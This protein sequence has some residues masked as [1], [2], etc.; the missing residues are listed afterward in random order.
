[1]SI[2]ENY[3]I[4]VE[5]DNLSFNYNNINLLEINSNSNFFKLPIKSPSYLFNNNSGFLFNPSYN[6]I[7]YS[8]SSNIFTNDLIVLG[9]LQASSFPSNVLILDEDNKINS[10]YLPSINNFIVYNTN[11]IAIGTSTP[12]ANIQL[13]DGNAYFKNS[14]IGIGTLP[15]YY[16]HLNK[17]DTM[18]LQ[19]AFVISSNSKHIIDIYTELETIVINNDGSPLDTNA[20]LN[21]M[22]LLKAN[23]I[24]TPYFTTSNKSTIINNELF[25]NNINSFQ[26]SIIIHSNID[27][28]LN[29]NS[30]GSLSSNIINLNTSVEFLNK[31]I[32]SNSNLILTTSN[33]IIDN[34][35]TSSITTSNLNVINIDSL[36]SNPSAESVMDFKGKIRLYNDTENVIIKIFSNDTQLFLIT[37]NNKLYS[38]SSNQVSLISSNFFYNTF[39]AKYNNYAYTFNNNLYLNGIKIL[40]NTII[41]DFALSPLNHIFY[42]NQIGEVISLNLSTNTQIVINNFINLRKIES[43]LDNSFIVLTNDNYIYHYVNNNYNI[44]TLSPNLII[45]D[46]AS[47]DDHTILQTNQ[48][49]WSFGGNTNNLTLKKGYS[50]IN[51]SSIGLKINYFNQTPKIV[52]I[53]VIK[54]SS[55][56]CDINSNVYI[57]GNINKLY[58]TQ[59]IYKIIDVNNV[60]DFCCDNNSV[61]LLSYF[62]DL[63]TLGDNNIPNTINLNEDF[64]GTSIKSKGSIVIG[65]EY[66]YKNNPR[67]SL[68]VQNFVGIGTN[69]SYN[70]AYSLIINGNINII[71][72][73]YN[74]GV[75]FVGG[76]GSGTSVW[77]KNVNDIYYNSGNVGVGLVK[78]LAPL[79]INGNAMFESNVIIKGK[80][81]AKDISPFIIKNSTNIYYR[82][83]VDINSL[84]INDG[85]FNINTIINSSN[86]IYN[87]L[88]QQSL[89]SSSTNTTYINPIIINENSSVIVSS[90]FTL[91]NINNNSNVLIYKCINNNWIKYP[92]RDIIS[93]NSSFGQS[94]AISKDGSNIFIGAYKDKL[95]SGIQT[96]GIYKYSFDN[97]NN[98]IRD[99]IRILSINQN[100]S[101][102]YIGNKIC[103]SSD[104]NILISTI[105][106]NNYKIYIQDIKENIEKIID[107]TPYNVFHTSFNPLNPNQ[108]FIDT[109]NDGSIIIMNYIFDTTINDITLFAYFNL[110]IIKDFDIY[111]LKFNSIHQNSFITSLSISSD[112]SRIFI[113]TTLGHH[114]IYEIDFLDYKTTN[115]NSTTIIKYFELQPSYY[116]YKFGYKGVLSKNGNFFHLSNSSIVYIYKYNSV[117]SIW[118][119]RKLLNLPLNIHN[120]S[121]S[122]DGNGF[123]I[124]IS[125]IK[126]INDTNLIDDIL[127]NNYLYNIHK[128]NLVFNYTSSNLNVNTDVFIN[129]NITCQNLIANGSNVYNVLTNNLVNN[130][131]QNGMMYTSNNLIYSSSNI[132]YNDNLKIFQFDTEG[133][134]TSNIYIL[135]NI[136]TASNI[137][138]TYGDIISGKGILSTSNIVSYSNII[139]TSNISTTYGNIRSAS[140]ISAI[141]NITAN[142]NII[143]GNRISCYFDIM[144]IYGN[145]K[146]G[147]NL[148]ADKDIIAINNISTTKGNIIGASNLFITSN[149][150][151]NNNIYGNLF[152]GDG[153]NLS[154]INPSNIISPIQINKGGTGRNY[155]NNNEIL[156]GNGSNYINSYN[157]FTFDFDT[158]TLNVSNINIGSNLILNGENFSNLNFSF[159]K[160][161]GINTF[162][163]GGLG[164]NR[165]SKSNLIFANESNKLKETPNLKWDEV[166]SNFRIDGNLIVKKI[167]GDGC[168][169]SNLRVDFETIG[170]IVPFHKG[171]LGFNKISKSNFIYAMEDNFVS[172]TSNIRWDTSNF[173]VDGN[174]HSQFFYGDGS[175]L[176]NIKVDFETIGGIIPFNKGGL[177]FNKISKSNLIFAN[178]DNQLIETSNIRWDDVNS[179]FIING[180]IYGDGLNISNINPLN[181]ISP[182]QI[183]KG[184]T[185]RNFFNNGEILFG[186]GYNYLNS[187][188]DFYL[189]I[190]TKTLNV[191]NINISSNIIFN[192]G[193]FSNLNFDFEQINGIIGFEKGGLGFNQI[194]KS[195]LIFA[196]EDNQ[197]KQTSNIRWDDVNSNFII[198]GYIFGDGS[199]I[200]N[201]NYSN[202]TGIINFEK[203]GLGFNQIS[204]SNLIFA[205]ENNQLKET[206]NIQWDE[207]NSNLLIKGY[208]FGDGSNISNLNYSNITGIINFE[209][210][211]LGFNQISKSNMI[212]ANENNKLKE[213]SNIRW[214]DVNSNLLIKGALNIGFNE[215]DE[216]YKIKVDGNIYLSG[217]VIGLSDINLKKNIEIIENPL[218]KINKLRGV[219][220]NYINNDERRQIGLIAQEVEKII[221][222]VV[223]ITNDDT[224]AIAYNNLIGLLIEGIKEL[225]NIIKSK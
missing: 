212:F 180:Y 193:N 136:S 61:Y 145:I 43:Y 66:F 183:D 40:D 82:G 137:S 78:P 203:G 27:L 25:I 151:V 39:K 44:I 83:K 101:Y 134:F 161:T 220:F 148:T 81:I 14:R 163:K 186:S 188:N 135:S 130:Y 85:T 173:F 32:R 6:S 86:L 54:N 149:I 47:G 21:V 70:P 171:G 150:F 210:G 144:T 22:G 156:I 175:N 5:N 205:N 94:L 102:N 125:I 91:D 77:K 38:Y 152:F 109:N 174:I 154:N 97:L 223:Y 28:I 172:E 158:N 84:E 200:S 57:F 74:N 34:L 114:Y 127:I 118:N 146:S 36:T 216:N 197:L 45:E 176:S 142:N 139:S 55:I 110:Y 224:K 7:T 195:N 95:Q 99:P 60:L 213:T 37:K 132:T 64:Y 129:S 16:F 167:Y 107:F 201:L 79:H 202:I 214:D 33:T 157:D 58:Q 24:K 209:K 122:I 52:S 69:I 111:F 117:L 15:S 108:I 184:G 124:T 140:N 218:D 196:N 131:N 153:S 115:L 169:I 63:F 50:T 160:I 67:N 119:E 104:G 199:N 93:D 89:V 49:L 2:Y 18:P 71:G 162:E 141:V 96:G 1:M 73:I 17:V 103:C 178:K 76:G 190:Q 8:A 182:I 165:I 206:S 62:N 65:G 116:F 19:P 208:I 128:N 143:G 155:F 56:V 88:L 192:G 112:N 23:E 211:G 92:I 189:D 187:T 113:S 126:K 46:I 179:N 3:K 9:K 222:E 87:D 164:F 181:I 159:D 75:L 170:G 120:Y 225:S 13:N 35:Q 123:N 72:S 90:Y 106:N 194:S 80:I 98:L 133:K 204:K 121:L 12:I 42:L 41:R 215:Y 68:L 30:I 26:S 59:Q 185:G 53:K 29:N 177:G 10:S 51:G 11:S 168:N 147:N 221:P 138:T 166:N 217:N 20:K 105:S 219:Y 48:G 198:D 4:S 207:V 31:N 100:N 191:R